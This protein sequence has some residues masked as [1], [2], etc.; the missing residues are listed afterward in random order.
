MLN[1]HVGVRGKKERKE[2]LQSNVVRAAPSRRVGRARASL[3]ERA[4]EDPIAGQV[5]RELSR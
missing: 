3:G 5:T 4:H 1:A 2:T